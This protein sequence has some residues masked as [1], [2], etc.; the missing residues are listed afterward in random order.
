MV[1]TVLYLKE[2]G[3]AF[4]HLEAVKNRFGSTIEIGILK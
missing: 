3:I 1:D 4:P 2:S